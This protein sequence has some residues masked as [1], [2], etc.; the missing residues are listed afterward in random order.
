[1]IGQRSMLLERFRCQP[2]LSPQK[3]SEALS[4]LL[5]HTLDNGR[6]LK[7]NAQRPG[8]TNHKMS[9][10]AVI[11]PPRSVLPLHASRVRFPLPRIRGPS[12]ATEGDEQCRTR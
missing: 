8:G 7:L 9:A 4:I 10:M 5:L 11:H 3:A 6:H 1:M 2:G 12:G